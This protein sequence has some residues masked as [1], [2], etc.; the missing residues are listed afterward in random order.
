MTE[1]MWGAILNGLISGEYQTEGGHSGKPS[2]ELK[3][4]IIG[5][6]VPWE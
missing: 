1:R 3:S 2:E 4:L 5:T 6:G